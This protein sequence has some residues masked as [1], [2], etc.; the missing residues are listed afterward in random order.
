MR[1]VHHLVKVVYVFVQAMKTC[2]TS[3]LSF[4]NLSQ[5]MYTLL[6][7][8]KFTFWLQIISMQKTFFQNKL[9]IL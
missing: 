1:S 7:R 3:N 5:E 4:E 8:L 2:K 6:F 9:V